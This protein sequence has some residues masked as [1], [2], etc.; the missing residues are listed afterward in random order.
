MSLTLNEKGAVSF[1]STF[2]PLVDLFGFGGSQIEW[3]KITLSEFKKIVDTCE[4][5]YVTNPQVYL[6]LLKYRR[7]IP[8]LGQKMMYYIM[9]TVV[10]MSN[11]EQYRSILEW[12]YACKKDWFRLARIYRMAD[13]ILPNP[14]TVDLTDIYQA[15][16]RNSSKIDHSTRKWLLSEHSSVVPIELELVVDELY[17][18]Y[19][20]Y[21][22]YKEYKK[23][24]NLLFKFIGTDHFSV[25]NNLIKRLLNQRLSSSNKNNK[26]TNSKLRRFYSHE[27]QKLHLFDNFLRGQ[28][29]DGSPLQNG[30]E[31]YVVG[32]MK[33]MS[34]LAF[35]HAKNVIS[36]FAESTIPYQRVLYKAYEILLEE[37]R[38]KSFY[39]KSTGWNPVKECY[40][41]FIKS[42]HTI[43]EELE[44][45]LTT[46]FNTIMEK[47]STM[48]IP[49]FDIVI[50]NSGSMDG[51]PIQTA[52]YISLLLTRL[53]SIDRVTIFNSTAKTVFLNKYEK[54]EKWSDR[55][56]SFYCKTEGSTNL[57]Q[58]FP[59][60]VNNS[61][62]TL[63]L[64][65]GDCDPTR[66]GQNPFQTA[67]HRFPNRKF[68]V[69]NLK[70]TKLNFPY[71]VNDQRV[72]YL[73]GNEPSVII[74]VIRLLANGKEL[75]PMN[76]LQ[77]CLDEDSLKWKEPN[78][79][80]NLNRMSE[81]Q[82]L[83]LY[84]AI[85]ANIP[86]CKM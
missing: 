17:R 23:G 14:A 21:K 13:F 52:L 68:V 36:K 9:L 58:I 72:G 20:E 15:F 25:E 28:K 37:I 27:K 42:E 83:R 16:L 3:E 86:I 46:K 67:L 44:S 43:N 38:S 1:S 65:D 71:C 54:E 11:P 19:N 31:G 51:T 48:S 60:L 41:Y 30:D 82:C 55:I 32:W 45:A 76:M 74:A 33:K 4:N 79:D 53:F 22:E 56:R 10:R 84:K 49:P 47:F 77:E 40:D 63:I 85:R 29:E 34:T 50:D 24:G 64:T 59:H 35:Q 18:E 78:L 61:N 81:D 73:S 66:D 6:Q 2:S 39:V 8:H 57:D 75:T 70:D 62:T 7:S 69:W 26:V 12:S 80:S 5:A